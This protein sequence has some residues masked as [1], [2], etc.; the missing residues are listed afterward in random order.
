M[1]LTDQLVSYWKADESSGNMADS[2]GSNTL[3]NNGTA[4]F[5]TGK[6]NNGVDLESGSTQYMSITDA[7]QTGLDLTGTNFSF[8]FWAKPES[9][10]SAGTQR[11]LIAK[12]QPA[13]GERQYQTY[14]YEDGG[15]FYLGIQITTTSGGVAQTLSNATW[16]MITYVFDD[17]A[18]SCE[19]F[20][21]GSS[22]GTISGL[23]SAV[24]DSGQEFRLGYSNGGAGL[25]DGMFDEIGVWNRKLTG[26]EVTS[27][28]NGGNGLAY[29]FTATAEKNFLTLLGAGA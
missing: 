22:I 27:L 18:N 23:T 11:A 9:Q 4:T 12:F 28:Y 5:A 24:T 20:V 26:A 29:P 25:W 2:V 17:T 10:P 13:A 6:I 8:N 21:N 15:V 3:T 19:V 16:Y 14:Y 1:A 7:A